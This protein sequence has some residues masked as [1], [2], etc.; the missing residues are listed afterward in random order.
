MKAYWIDLGTKIV[1]I[2]GKGASKS[3]TAA[4]SKVNRSMVKRYVKQLGQEC[5]LVP[6]KKCLPP[7]VLMTL[8]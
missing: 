7:V 3:E 5:S 6:K 1:E 4:R 2:L 8:L